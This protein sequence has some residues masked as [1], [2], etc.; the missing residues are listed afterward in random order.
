MAFTVV[1]R[2]HRQRPSD[3]LPPVHLPAARKDDPSH[4]A[5]ASGLHG[6]VNADNI[7]RQKLREE[8]RVIGCSSEKNQR[9]NADCSYFQCLTIADVTDDR[10]SKARRQNPV[11]TADRDVSRHQ[12]GHDGLTYAPGRAQDKNGVISFQ[13]TANPDRATL[14][15]RFSESKPATTLRHSSERAFHSFE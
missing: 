4:S 11:K 12:L 2:A 8:I 14:D 7:V 6:V 1:P 5:R 3:A 13:F 9:A 15:A 10:V